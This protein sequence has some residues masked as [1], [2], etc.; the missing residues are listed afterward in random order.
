[1]QPNDD[2]DTAA[3]YRQLEATRQAANTL[4]D[5]TLKI[6]K[7]AADSARKGVEHLFD[8]AEACMGARDPEGVTTL[9]YTCFGHSPDELL[10]VQ[11]KMTDIVLQTGVALGG[12]LGQ[13]MPLAFLAGGVHGRAVAEPQ[14]VDAA[15]HPVEP[16]N[17]WAQAW[18]QYA[19]TA[20]GWLGAPAA[21]PVASVRKTPAKR[22]ATRARR[23]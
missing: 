21:V 17:A 20:N 22:A 6:E 7:L 9:Q 13:M 8:F 10:E 12:A 1:M 4:L 14:V 16:F 3:Y 11:K 18:R 19:Q 5:G 15:A 2:T 23:R